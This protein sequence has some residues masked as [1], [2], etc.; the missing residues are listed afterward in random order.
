MSRLEEALEKAM[1]KRKKQVR[2]DTSE[3]IVPETRPHPVKAKE[4]N[5]ISP[6]RAY[7]SN[8]KSRHINITNPYLITATDPDSPISEEYR[9]LKSMVVKLTKM[10]DFNN[11]LLV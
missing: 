8:G 4:E 10:D 11:T 9:K 3:D 2:E 5:I 7:R 6:T 1:I